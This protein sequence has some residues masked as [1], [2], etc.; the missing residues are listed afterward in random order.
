MSNRIYI[1]FINPLRFV[2][3]ARTNQVQYNTKQFDDYL[4]RE[5]ILDFEQN[6]CWRQPFSPNDII[7]LQLSANYSPIQVSFV[8]AKYGNTLSTF[9]LTSSIRNTY[10]PDYFLYEQ[11][12]NISDLPEG[13]YYVRIDAGSPVQKTLLSETFSISSNIKNTLF[14]EYENSSFYEDVIFETGI[15]FGMRIPG[16]IAAYEP[17][18]KDVVYEDQ[19]LDNTILSSI[20]YRTFKL[21]VGAGQGVPD[22]LIDKV[23]R[24]MGCDTVTI[25]GKGF[26]KPDGSKWEKAEEVNYPM[27]GWTLPLREAINR[28][29]SIFDSEGST[30]KRIIVVHN[31][32]SKGFGDIFEPGQNVVEIIELE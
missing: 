20:P 27:R 5:Q 13:C 6:V 12:F 31:I 2:D 24:I 29:S 21:F 26:S 15:K 4:F 17:A 7:S 22:W 9:S 25:D 3:A 16:F 10:Q 14:L 30:D 19:V 11:N 18:S 23:N 8:G 1:P 32:D 28:K